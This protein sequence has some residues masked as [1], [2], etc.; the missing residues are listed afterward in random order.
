MRTRLL[1]FT[2]ALLVLAACDDGSGGSTTDAPDTTSGSTDTTAAAPSSTIPDTTTTLPPGTEELPE[3]IRVELA[4]LMTITQEVRQLEFQEQ[5]NVAVVSQEELAQRVRDQLEEDLADL[6]ADEALYRLLGLVD[7]DTDLE[8]LYSDL[9]SEQVAGFYD[10]EEREL[11]VPRAEEGFTALQRATLVHE[12]THALTDQ[13]YGFHAV[14]STLLDEE[15][16]DEASAL[17]ALIEGDAVLAELLYLQN[18]T[19]EEQAQFLTESF[20]VDQ[21]VFES[22]PQF[23]RDALVFPYDSGFLFVERLYRTGGFDAI[24]DAYA[25]PPTSTEQIID[26]EDYPADEP[27]PVEMEPLQIDGYELEYQSTWGE[28]SFKLMFDQALSA[29][30]SDVAAGGWGGD[31]YQVHFNGTDVV[32]VLIYRGDSESDGAELSSALAEYAGTAMDTGEGSELSDGTAFVGEDAAWVGAD[33]AN[34]VFIASSDPDLLPPLVDSVTAGTGAS[35][36]G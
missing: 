28:L 36:E 17:Q 13:H 6:P 19:P 11:V 20:G 18:L 30:T 15:R 1:T 7:D 22:A 4:E 33:G 27:I 24:A 29:E 9:Y 34:V 26:P 8:Q 25:D 10:G 2:L 16:Y 23:I 35:Q 3:E 12:L 14:Y 31:S 21:E 5:P 32:L